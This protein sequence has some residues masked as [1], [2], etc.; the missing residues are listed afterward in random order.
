M[1]AVTAAEGTIAREI[2]LIRHGE[3][4]WSL[5][6]QHTGRTDIALTDR[7]CEEARALAPRLAAQR[8]DVVLSSPMTRALETCRL[9]GLGDAAQRE[10]ELREWDY[11]QYEGL[12]TPQIRAQT[13]DWTVWSG[14]VPGGESLEQINARGNALIDRLLGMM[15]A[16]I[17]LFSHAHFLRALAGCWIGDSASLGAHFALDTA[18][19]SILGFEHEQRA[20]R[21][22]NLTQ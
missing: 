17:A 2:W 20:I 14:P 12:T 19:V 16:R 10:P 13:P 3:T 11:G 18:S 4:E 22:W 15:P 8:F 6:G 7:G 9:A 21:R 5:S 1:S